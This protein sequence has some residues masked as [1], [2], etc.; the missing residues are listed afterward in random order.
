MRFLLDENFP[1]AAKLVLE[2]LGHKVLDFRLE[3]C[4][5]APDSD[6]INF[7]IENQAVILSTD[8]DFFHTLGQQYPEHFGILVIALKS[9]NREAILER[10]RWFLEKFADSDVSGRSF[11][12]RDRAWLV[13][14]P[15]S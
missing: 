15:L 4:E 14:P 10:L 8:R 12:L 11:Q 3:G 5:G 6:V 13:Y 7:A 1:K 2:E 9:P